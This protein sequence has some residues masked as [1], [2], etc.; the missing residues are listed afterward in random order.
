MFSSLISGADTFRENCDQIGLT[1]LFSFPEVAKR[2]VFLD[3]LRNF[4]DHK[5]LRWI[6]EK[7][8]KREKKLLTLSII[9]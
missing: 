8:S 1:F 3:C 5:R 4:I 7:A 2:K 6:K 9:I